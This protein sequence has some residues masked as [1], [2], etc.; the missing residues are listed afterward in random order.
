VETDALMKPESEDVNELLV[1]PCLNSS[2]T[3]SL[4][5]NTLTFLLN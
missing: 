3:F 2:R 5:E 1:H 4:D